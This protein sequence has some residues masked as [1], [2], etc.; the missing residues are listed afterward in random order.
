M[1]SRLIGEPL[2]ALRMA[3]ALMFRGVDMPGRV[4]EVEKDPWN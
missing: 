2:A 4:R 1:K 3:F